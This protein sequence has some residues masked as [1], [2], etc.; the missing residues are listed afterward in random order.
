MNFLITSQFVYE[1]CKQRERKNE[2]E[3][4]IYINKHVH[5]KYK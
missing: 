2:K 3:T 1:R 4:N 5:V